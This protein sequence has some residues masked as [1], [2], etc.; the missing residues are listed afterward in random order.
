MIL[1]YYTS[2]DP[3]C[4]DRLP[5]GIQGGFQEASKEVSK[6][7]RNKLVPRLQEASRGFKEASKRLQEAPRGFKMHHI[8]ILGLPRGLTVAIPGLHIAILMFPRGLIIVILGLHC[9]NGAGESR[10][11]NPAQAGRV[12][13]PTRER[14]QEAN[15][16]HRREGLGFKRHPRGIQEASRGFK[17]LPSGYKRLPR[18]LKRPQEASRGSKRPSRAIL[19]HRREGLEA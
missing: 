3:K 12:D 10:R 19:T 13:P 4:F 16:T 9:K 5:R 17:R 6:R 14:L 11:C 15:L 7:P 18:G 2:I 1:R 8:A